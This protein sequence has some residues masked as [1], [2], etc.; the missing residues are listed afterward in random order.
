MKT[1]QLTLD[2]PLLEA[3]DRV[4]EA[5]RETR[6]AFVRTALQ[7][8]LKRRQNAMREEAH[9]KSYLEQSVDEDAWQPKKRAWGDA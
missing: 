8:E 9:R 3:I 2:E 6:S 4:A 1:V 7:A 5:H